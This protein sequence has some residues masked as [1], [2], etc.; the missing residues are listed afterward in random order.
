M[1]LSGWGRHPVVDAGQAC[2]TGESD[3]LALL[4]SLRDDQSL[5][6]RGLGRSYG[7]S[8]LAPL[9]LD[10]GN[11]DHLLAFDTD[12]G[13][14]RCEAGVSLATLLQ[15]FVPRGWFPAVTPGTKFVTVG[16]A[17]ASDVHGKNHH[18]DGSFSDHVTEMRVATPEHGVVTCSRSE[19]PELFHATAGGMGLTGLIL[20][21]TIRLKRIQ[22]AAVIETTLKAANLQEALDLFEA[23]RSAT[24][25]VAWIDCLTAGTAM[26]RSIISLGEHADQGALVAHGSQKIAVPV[27]LPGALLNPLSIRAFNTLYYQRVRRKTSTAR[28]HYDP[29]FYPLD[30]IAN[31]NRMYGRRGFVQYQLALPQD[32]G[33]AGLR[34]VLTRIVQSGRGSFL[35]VLKA[36]G[37]GNANPLSFP[38]RGYTLALDFKLGAGVLEL[39]DELDAI[40]IDHGGRLY[41]TKD[42]RMSAAT[43][44]RCYPA[45]EAFA[46]VRRRYGADR[47]FHS[48]QSRRLE[49]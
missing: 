38:I 32:A 47:V 29:C 16:G 28:R 25:S 7:D 11:M 24:Y 20:D 19:H 9:V 3:A 39:L 42:A 12:S 2:P 44:R 6:P 46:E 31:W 41:L 26:G 35:A 14:L 13:L 48:Q 17:I 10:T 30:G 1:K 49:I 43:F 22:S 5:I 33:V 15:V 37:D 36:F 18:V 21:A 34:E 45:W 23:H 40:V 27:D 4:A 8:S